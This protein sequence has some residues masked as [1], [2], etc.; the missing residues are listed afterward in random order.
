[1]PSHQL[2]HSLRGIELRRYQHVC[3]PDGCQNSWAH[4]LGNPMV[5]SQGGITRKQQPTRPQPAYIYSRGISAGYIARADMPG[6]IHSRLGL[7]RSEAQL[8]Q[9]WKPDPVVLHRGR[10]GSADAGS[11]CVCNISTG[12][13]PLRHI[14]RHWLC[15]GK[16]ASTACRATKCCIKPALTCCIYLHI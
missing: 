14:F 2:T 8:A 5:A 16:Q 10:C 15:E 1:M 6:N 11:G 13:L 4:S 3:R 7:C 9:L 12:Q